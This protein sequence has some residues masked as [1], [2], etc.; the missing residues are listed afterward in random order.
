MSRIGLIDLACKIEGFLTPQACDN[1]INFYE[2][3]SDKAGVE[4]STNTLTRQTEVSSFTCVTPDEGSIEDTSCKE[5]F[6]RCVDEW[7]KYL[8]QF[9]VVDTPELFALCS[10]VY[11][12]RVLKYDVGQSIHPHTD[13]ADHG[14]GALLRAS[15]TVNL[16]DH[17][18]YTGG[19]FNLLNDRYSI[20]LS[21]GDVLI[22]PASSFWVHSVSPVTSG[23]RYSLN[24]FLGPETTDD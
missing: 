6:T 8:E 17:S 21:K 18:E 22:F 2:E 13:V 11:S 16:S 9:N 12:Y 1:L 4:C 19:E 15:C 5:I 10:K 20:K 3:N 14:Y 24:G 23:V 7:L